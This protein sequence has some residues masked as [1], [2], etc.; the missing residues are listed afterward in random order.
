MIRLVSSA[1]RRT[2]A[3]AVAVV[4]TAPWL[5]G[6]ETNPATGQS[7]FSLMSREQE[8]QIG[9]QESPKAI[10][11]FGGLYD[12][13]ELARYIDSIGQLLAKTTETPDQ[14]FT[15]VVLDSD[16]VNA[17]ALPGG[18]V[19]VTRGLLA[20]A[21]NEA[22]AAGVIAHEI[23]HV[24][25]R[26]AAQRTSQAQISSAL[27]G[28]VGGLLLG[29]AGA[30]LG[31]YGASAYVA[32]YSRDQEFEA[33]SLGVRYL[34]RAGF[35]PEA[36]ADFLASLQMQS[37]LEAQIAGKKDEGADIMASHPRT[38]DRVQAAIKA[39]STGAPVRNPVDDRDIYL[40]KIDGIIYGD[41]P[42]SGFVR[43]TRFTHPVLGFAF[44]APQNF[45]LSNQPSQVVAKGPQ[46]GAILFSQAQADIAPMDYLNKISVS[47]A[48]FGNI[49]PL[50]VN[51]MQAAMGTLR[52]N[53]QNGPVELRLVAVR[54]GPNALYQ[55]VSLAPAQIADQMGDALQRTV[56]TFH[57]LSAQEAASLRPLRV[58]VVSVR[59]GDTVQSLAARTA[60]PDNK[61]QRFLVLNGLQQNSTLRPGQLIKL[62]VE[63]NPVKQSS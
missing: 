8:Q 31:Q 62:V 6:C 5:A 53:T 50:S 25:A 46:G 44:E 1:R 40:R 23:G 15:F 41:S 18:Y 12:D 35:D 28:L 55:F 37:M 49:Q 29:D 52:G 48:K 32:S 24:V 63:G 43:G 45:K 9:A 14:K 30:Q 60:F 58:Q 61:L 51:G 42:K 59:A 22:E 13:P 34:S 56:S 39:A 47:G 54:F 11:Q 3:A 21:N 19:H 57:R 4:L 27:G 7:M 10:E 17:F 16:I 38:Q 26:H 33:D 20:L 2:L 36:M